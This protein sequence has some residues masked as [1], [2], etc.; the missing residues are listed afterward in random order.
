[1]RG[2]APWLLGFGLV[3]GLALLH[4]FAGFAR[5]PEEWVEQ[6]GFAAPEASASGETVL[7][8]EVESRDLLERLR[9][10]FPRARLLVSERD[11]VAIEGCIFAYDLEAVSGPLN[12]LGWA[13]RRID[14]VSR[15]RGP[16]AD[17]AG[18]SGGPPSSGTPAA[19]PA[20]LADLAKKP[21]L[22]RSDA[23]ALL[24]ELEDPER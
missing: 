18:F 14:L 8:V 3:A 22:T 1:M 23:L 17:A 16:V 12:R 19:G 7:I 20:R 6:S 9:G 5:A 2:L 13:N 24:R 15:P 21:E 4:Q 10:R 11:V